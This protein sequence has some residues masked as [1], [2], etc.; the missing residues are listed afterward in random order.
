MLDALVENIHGAHTKIQ[1]GVRVH[2]MRRSLHN[3]EQ[4][5]T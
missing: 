5:K 1:E 4:K 2:T 3:N